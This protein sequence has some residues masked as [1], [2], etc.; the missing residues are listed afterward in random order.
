WLYRQLQWRLSTRSPLLA[1]WVG[2]HVLI[3]RS[4][5]WSHRR[6]AR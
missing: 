2:G 6:P 5:Y 1:G 4:G 3:T